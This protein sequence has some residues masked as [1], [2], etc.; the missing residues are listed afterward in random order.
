MNTV[1]FD[2]SSRIGQ[3]IDL[4]MTK[5][6]ATSLAELVSSKKKVQRLRVNELEE[7][8]EWKINLIEEISL[9]RKGLINLDFEKE[10]MEDILEQLCTE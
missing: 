5:Y 10:V 9:V 6:D 7:N 3:N 8:E 2:K 4:L 1:K